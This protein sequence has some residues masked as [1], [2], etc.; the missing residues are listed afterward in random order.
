MSIGLKNAKTYKEKN[1]KFCLFSRL[2]KKIG[3]YVMRFATQ[4]FIDS[5]YQCLKQYFKER[6]FKSLMLTTLAF[7]LYFKDNTK[8]YVILSESDLAKLAFVSH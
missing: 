2:K 5:V 1:L 7:F 4:P 3:I 6:Y 8:N